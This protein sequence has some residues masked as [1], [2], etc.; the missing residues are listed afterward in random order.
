MWTDAARKA[1]A[2]ARASHIMDWGGSS[3]LPGVGYMPRY[4]AY[5][6]RVRATPSGGYKLL[7]KVTS[8]GSSDN[9]A[10]LQDKHGPAPVFR[11]WSPAHQNGV[12]GV[13]K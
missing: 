10:E 3:R 4:T 9:L 1:A 5:T 12:N 13:A 6:G 2:A 7:S 11:G 8:L